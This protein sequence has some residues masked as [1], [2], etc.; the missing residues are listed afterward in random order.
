MRQPLKSEA[1]FSRNQPRA[2][3]PAPFKPGQSVSSK[4]PAALRVPER[5]VV[6]GRAGGGKVGP[7]AHAPFKSAPQ[8][9]PPG[10]G[11]VP[12]GT[13]HSKNALPVGPLPRLGS[14]A[15]PRGAASGNSCPPLG[16][17]DVAQRLLAFRASEGGISGGPV[18]GAGPQGAARPSWNDSSAKKVAV[19]RHAQRLTELG[20]RGKGAQP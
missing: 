12:A 7:S 4:G 13:A 8:R 9:G 15:G 18:P 16:R 6:P 1:F 10:D 3:M 19:G 2:A 14:L 11:G 5:Q 17:P 20:N